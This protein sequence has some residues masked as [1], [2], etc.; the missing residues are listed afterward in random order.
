MK[1]TIGILLGLGMIACGGVQQPPPV[2]TA[3]VKDS[4]KIFRAAML[5]SK[6]DPACGMP[7]TAA[8]I[9]TLVIKGKVVGFC[10]KECKEAYLKDP[11]QYPIEYK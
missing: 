5:D 2:H 8:M 3:P 7:S 4:V 9:D 1:K 11:K 6:K 10:S